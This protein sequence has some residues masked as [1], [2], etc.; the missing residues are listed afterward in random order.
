MVLSEL[1][2]LLVEDARLCRLSRRSVLLLALLPLLAT[3]A[4]GL[5]LA[6][7]PT[8]E[9]VTREDGP[10][11][12]GQVLCFL[13]AAGAAAAAAVKLRRRDRVTAILVGLFALAAL[14]AAGEEI[15]WGQRLLG[16]GTPEALADI[17]HQNETTVHNIMPVQTA[18]NY[19][20]LLAGFYGGVVAPI[21][22][23]R[24]TS[25]PVAAEFVLPPAF[26]AP[27]FLVMFGYRLVRVTVLTEDRFVFVKS[28]EMPELVFAF[29]LA[30]MAVLMARRAVP[31]A[32]PAGE[33]AAGEAAPAVH[34]ALPRQT[35]VATAADS[36]SGAPDDAP[37]PEAASP[38]V[39]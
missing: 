11:E 23:A 33:A 15:S 39:E 3:V 2:A 22:R 7:R 14:F 25:R 37:R 28:G 5:T 13:V 1:R 16:W 8:F 10:L 12:W 21:L 30:S 24:W 29:A 34:D 9:T 18:F 32:K 20:Q 27:A 19:V 6:H 26:L 38:L 31:A 4:F 36:S 17:N 35:G